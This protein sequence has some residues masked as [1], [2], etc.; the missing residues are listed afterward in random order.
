MSGGF[1]EN[2]VLRR[3]FGPKREQETH[4]EES[5]IIRRSITCIYNPVLLRDKM[6]K[7]STPCACGTYGKDG[8]YIQVLVR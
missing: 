7:D 1:S 3:K 5:C 8:K 4:A 2:R 6:M